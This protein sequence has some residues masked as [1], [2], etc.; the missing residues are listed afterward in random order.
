VPGY[1]SP[2]GVFSHDNETITCRDG[3]YHTIPL[4]QVGT[5]TS[6]CVDGGE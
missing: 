5:R 3:T 2:E 1:D 4:D 6:L